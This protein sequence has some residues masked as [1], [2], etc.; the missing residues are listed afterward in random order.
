MY[1]GTDTIVDTIVLNGYF[2]IFV[3]ES[4][5]KKNSCDFYFLFSLSNYSSKII[6]LFLQIRPR[7]SAVFPQMKNIHTFSTDLRMPK[8]FPAEVRYH[9][10]SRT[11]V[12]FLDKKV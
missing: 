10:Y 1:H 8:W 7:I 5:N 2:R 3:M 6:I 12:L 4:I 9:Q 11:S